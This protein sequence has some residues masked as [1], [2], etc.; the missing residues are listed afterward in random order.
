MDGAVEA[1]D[2]D[3]AGVG[4]NDVLGVLRERVVQNFEAAHCF[5]AL[6]EIRFGGGGNHLDGFGFRV[7]AG[8]AGLRVTFRLQNFGLLF[9][10]GLQD[11]ALLDAFRFENGS[12]LFPFR[13]HLSL[14]P[15]RGADWN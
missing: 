10:F 11:L 9:A 12:A 3:E 6:F 1:E 8:D 13:F 5:R 4:R 14:R 15:E 7:G 2:V